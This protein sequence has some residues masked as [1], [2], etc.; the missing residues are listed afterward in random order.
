MSMDNLA[1]I[2]QQLTVPN[3]SSTKRQKAG[4]GPEGSTQHQ[5]SFFQLSQ[6]QQVVSGPEHDYL[7]NTMVALVPRVTFNLATVS[8]VHWDGQPV[9][10][11]VSACVAPD[12]CL[13]AHLMFA[14]YM[15]VHY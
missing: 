8:H 11:G 2:V 15:F 1:I 13:D 14:V 4:Q 12:D 10:I 5:T 9:R 6:P 3:A 7:L